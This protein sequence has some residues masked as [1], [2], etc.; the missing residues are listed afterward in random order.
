MLYGKHNYMYNV[1]TYIMFIMI[2][3]VTIVCKYNNVCDYIQVIF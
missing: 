3:V 2:F 1:Y